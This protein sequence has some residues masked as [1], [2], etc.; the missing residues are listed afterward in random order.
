MKQRRQTRLQQWLLPVL[1]C[2]AVF[3]TLTA[4]PTAR[5]QEEM[6]L[7]WERFDF[8]KPHKSGKKIIC[9]HTPQGAM[10]S[11]IGYAACIDTA[12]VFGGW[13][14]CLDVLSGEYWQANEFRD[15]RTGKVE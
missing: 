13:L 6:S 7:Y 8:I 5:A 9:G 15:V 3:L 12:A 14:T 1:L 10:I 4:V 11:D 2:L